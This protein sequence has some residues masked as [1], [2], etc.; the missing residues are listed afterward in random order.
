M[1]DRT[2]EFSARLMLELHSRYEKCED[3]NA[4][5]SSILLAV[6]NA[7]AH[8]RDEM[9]YGNPDN[10]NRAWREIRSKDVP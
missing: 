3:F 4:T 6:I 1:T 9:D 5:P 7:I 8:V 10:I 2:N